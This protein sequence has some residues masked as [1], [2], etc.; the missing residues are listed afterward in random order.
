MTKKQAIRAGDHV[1]VEGHERQYIVWAT[2][3]E[4]KRV[5]CVVPYATFDGP[6]P[7]D[8]DAVLDK[9]D[10]R[11]VLVKRPRSAERGKLYAN[12]FHHVV[13]ITEVW[14][15]AN[16]AGRLSFTQVLPRNIT[17]STD[18]LDVAVFEKKYPHHVVDVEVD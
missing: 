11:H 12:N 9:V 13:L 18:V 17:G 6:D 14:A 3:D 15:S 2:H 5:T 7:D 8:D 4:G 10:H 16:G 1:F